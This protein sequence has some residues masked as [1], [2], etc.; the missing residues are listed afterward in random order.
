METEATEATTEASEGTE[1]TEGVLSEGTEAGATEEASEEV[2]TDPNL[3]LARKF[4]QLTEHERRL[5][6]EQTNFRSEQDEATQIKEQLAN[7]KSDPLKALEALGI[8]FKDIA[9]QVLND[10]KPTTE[11]KLKSLEEQ[12]LADK[13]SREAEREKEKTEWNEAEE[14][15]LHE[16]ATETM[17]E[18]KEIIRQ[19]VDGDEEGKY[20]LVK[21]QGAYDTVWDVVQE[22]FNETDTIIP[23]EE[24]AAKVEEYLEG[25]AEK[26]LSTDKFK[27]RYRQ[28]ESE[29]EEEVESMGHNHYQQKMLEE[30]VVIWC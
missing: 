3:D 5:R 14:A 25:E 11:Q 27:K 12:I 1:A 13:A 30:R 15:E 21:Q 10:E 22:V 2:Q 19:F 24:A 9:E 23:F 6:D 29:P 20:E 17:D 8:S 26:F 7:L 18:S 28:I 4:N 16:A